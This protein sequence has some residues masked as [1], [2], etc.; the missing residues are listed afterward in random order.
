MH[1]VLCDVHVCGGDGQ[2]EQYLSAGILTVFG[3]EKGEERESGSQN[4]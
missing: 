2:G 3:R 1:G 4:K